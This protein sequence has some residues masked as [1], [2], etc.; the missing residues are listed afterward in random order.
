MLL[1]S[2]LMNTLTNGKKTHEVKKETMTKR[3]PYRRKR[4][5]TTSKKKKM[6]A[7]QISNSM[8]MQIAKK[9]LLL[10]KMLVN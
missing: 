1:R 7:I 4:N 3:T 9:L 8:M 2:L 6:L 5:T 10:G